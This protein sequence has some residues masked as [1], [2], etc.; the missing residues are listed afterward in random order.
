MIVRE[1]LTRLGFVTDTSGAKKYDSALGGIN[2]KAVALTSTL[3]GMMT[4]AAAAFSVKAI[5][6]T[7][8]QVTSLEA[9]IAQLPQTVGKSGD[10]FNYLVEKANASRQP[11]EAYMTLYTRIGYATKELLPTQQALSGVID[12]ISQSFVMGGSAASE[13]AAAMLQLSQAFNKGKLDGDEFR[14]VMENMPGQVTQ[15][16]AEAM[17]YLTKG[18]LMKA[19]SDGKLVVDELVKGFQKI[20]PEI[21][22][23]FMKMPMT[24]GQATAIASNKWARFLAKMNRESGAVTWMLGLFNKLVDGLEKFGDASVKFFGNSTNLVKFLAIAITAVLLPAL[25]RLA[26]SMAAFLLSPTGLL[27]TGLIAISV[28]LEDIYQWTQDNES[29]TGKWIGT[30]AEFKESVIA[31]WGELKTAFND[32]IDHFVKHW[33]DKW[34]SIKNTTQQIADQISA[35]VPDW[36]K[37]LFGKGADIA[38]NIGGGVSDAQSKFINPYAQQGM[39]LSAQGLAASSAVGVQNSYSNGVTIGDIN[40][41]VSN[42]NATAQDI[43]KETASAV[44]ARARV[45]GLSSM[46]LK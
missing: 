34:D 7:L 2:N 5:A 16:L 12:T 23:S 30:Y 6:N 45:G 40:V 28:M 31:M 8:D 38:V 11:I 46:G 25:T 26:V 44:A 21:E 36:I 33:A 1:L 32:A 43:A 17:G 14:S 37:D 20:G 15:S 27:L 35:L 29:M 19:S 41:S 9:K 3:Q 13:Q 42:T 4:A 10:A 18:D 39:A 24:I 22:K